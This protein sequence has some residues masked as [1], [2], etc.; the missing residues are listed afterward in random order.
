VFVILTQV[1]PPRLEISRLALHQVELVR[2]ELKGDEKTPRFLT[3]IIWS[4]SAPSCNSLTLWV[5]K[6]IC[7]PGETKSRSPV[8]T[9][10]LFRL[11]PAGTGRRK[12][13]FCQTSQKAIGLLL[14]IARRGRDLKEHFRMTTYV[15]PCVITHH[16]NA[17]QPCVGTE[18]FLFLW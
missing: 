1:L 5:L 8:R 3:A 11:Y 14:L 13:E 4:R 7:P 6:F 15:Y 2:E 16:L 18:G 12:S 10:T 9:D 17:D